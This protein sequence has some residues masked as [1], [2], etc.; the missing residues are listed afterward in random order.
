MSLSEI[1]H[2]DVFIDLPKRN[3]D[4]QF[5]AVGA[6]QDTMAPLEFIQNNRAFHQQGH[7]R[8]ANNTKT[9]RLVS[10]V[11]FSDRLVSI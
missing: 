6:P 1:S 2:V 10:D 3:L 7:S 8:N 11:I 4:M 5:V 9:S